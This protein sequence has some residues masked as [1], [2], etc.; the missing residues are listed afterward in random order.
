MVRS[1]LLEMATYIQ[2]PLSRNVYKEYNV[3]GKDI[4]RLP[5]P[6]D[7]MMYICIFEI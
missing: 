2:F 3:D 6:S 7:S 1:D 4:I 5:L